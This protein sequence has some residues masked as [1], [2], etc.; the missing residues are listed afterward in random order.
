VVHPTHQP[1]STQV[2][3]TYCHVISAGTVD[4]MIGSVAHELDERG[5]SLKYFRSVP[6]CDFYPHYTHDLDGLFRFGGCIPAIHAQADIRELVLLGLQWFG[7]GGGLLVRRG[8]GISGVADLAGRKIGLYR[9][10]NPKKTDWRR[11]TEDRG[12]ELIL[13]L[14]GMS[15]ADVEIVD[16]PSADD[17]YDRPESKPVMPTMTDYWRRSRMDDD[18]R[19]HA[20]LDDLAAGTIDAC[21]ATD[22]FDLRYADFPDLVM[23][24]NLALN[25]DWT[26]QVSSAPYSLTCTRTFADEHPDLVTAFVKGLVRTGRRCNEDPAAAA[27][28]L[29][30]SGFFPPVETS[31]PKL[32]SLDFIPNL[33]AENLSAI[34]IESEF[35]FR[36]GYISRPVDVH[37]WAEAGFLAAAERELADEVETGI[38]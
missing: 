4:E 10:L 33:S 38:A 32:A 20:L 22:P 26:L 11:I 8:A 13:G 7:E 3:Y 1:Q 23:I 35:M 36:R 9:S 19:D 27:R 12:I 15:R 18:L 16:C 21:F 24:E 17:W 29:S 5:A 6:E 34:E 14:G 37:D 28:L 25:P 31:G 2:W 30:E